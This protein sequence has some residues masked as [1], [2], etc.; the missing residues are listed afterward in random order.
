MKG[1]PMLDREGI[2]AQADDGDA[3]GVNIFVVDQIIDCA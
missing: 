2:V 3:F 1:L